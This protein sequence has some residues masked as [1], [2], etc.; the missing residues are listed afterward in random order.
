MVIDT[1][2]VTATTEAH[3]KMPQT[4][5]RERHLLITRFCGF[6]CGETEDFE[7]KNKALLRQRCA[8]QNYF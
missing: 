4:T 6:V 3:G 5:T 2:A 7:G 8:S 1:Y